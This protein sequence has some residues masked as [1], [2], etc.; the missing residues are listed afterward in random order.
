M[1]ACPNGEHGPVAPTATIRR[2]RRTA[3]ILAAAAVAAVAPAPAGAATTTAPCE[4]ADQAPT[5]A[6]GAQARAAIVCLIDAARAER[7]LPALRRDRRLTTAAQRFAR[8]LDRHRPL[9]HQGAGGSSPLDRIAAA[10]Y[11]DGA[12]IT[13]GEALG[14]GQ[15]SYATPVVRVATWLQDATTRRILLSAR[16]RD[17]GVGVATVRGV[18]TYVADLARRQPVSSASASASPRPAR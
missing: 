4:G 10:G 2:L 9:K 12:G 8:A 5:T 3:L 1:A 6:T 16:Y 7:G 18:A 17:I 14:R 15:G 11:A 13:A